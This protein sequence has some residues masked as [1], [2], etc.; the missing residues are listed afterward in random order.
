M[1][2]KVKAF[3]TLWS[4]RCTTEEPTQLPS[5]A[6]VCW[7]SSA[8]ARPTRGAGWTWFCFCGEREKRERRTG[9]F[10][11]V[12]K[13]EEE[14]IEKEKKSSVSHPLQPLPRVREPVAPPG[15]GPEQVLLGEHP[16]A[17]HVVGD[18]APQSERLPVNK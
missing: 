5:W 16:E 8:M 4:P 15:P 2:I 18:G 14:K 12:L 11:C 9:E 6:C 17:E 13:E 3:G 10:F 1:S 7:R